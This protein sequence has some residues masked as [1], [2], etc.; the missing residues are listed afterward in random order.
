[1]RPRLA[2]RDRHGKHAAG[3]CR[4]GPQGAG[5]VSHL[6]KTEFGRGYRLLGSWIGP[7]ARRPRPPVGVQRINLGRRTASDQFSRDR[8][9]A[10]WPGRRRVARLRDLLS[11]YRLVTLTGPGGI[12]KTSLAMKA[13]RGILG[14]FADGGWLVELASLSDPELVPS[15]VARILGIKA[16]GGAITPEIIARAVRRRAVL[17]GPRQ[18]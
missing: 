9:A 12:G 15:A 6:L 8:H 3:S 5:P 2:R 10:H 13:A 7:A 18:L 16:G 17:A 1:M 4:G 14:D 11:A